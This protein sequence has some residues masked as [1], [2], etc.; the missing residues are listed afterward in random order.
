M[1]EGGRNQVAIA[2]CSTPALLAKKGHALNGRY[3]QKDAYD[4]YYCIRNYPTGIE[5]LAQ[6]CRPL[7]EPASGVKYQRKV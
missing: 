4:I 3:K 1:P 6:D 2:V 7:L 5:A